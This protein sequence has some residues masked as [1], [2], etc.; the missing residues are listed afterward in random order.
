MQQKTKQMK[1][2][3]GMDLYSKGLTAAANIQQDSVKASTRKT[4]TA[5]V[6]ELADWLHSI[7]AAGKRTLQT[8]TPED[9]L[10]YFT[11]HWLPNHAGSATATGEFIAAPS[12]L[13]GIKSHLATEFETLG[14]LGPWD[15]HTKAGNPTHSK[16]I[17]DMLKGYGNQATQLGY[18]KKGA[19]PL[20]QAEMHL[21][22][23][24][25]EQQYHSTTDSAQLLLLTRD[26]LLFSMLWQT[27]FR[28]FNAGAVRL[29]NIVLPTGGSAL[30]FLVPATTLAAGAVLHV[31]PD[32]TKNKKGGHCPVTL[33]CD[34]LC[35]STWLERATHHYAVAG[36]PITNFLTRPLQ[37]GSKTLF[38]EKPMSSSNAWASLTKH[39][40]ALGIYT[41]QSVHSTRRGKMIHKQLNLHESHK[42]ISE[43]AMC[44]EQNAKYYTDIHRPTRLRM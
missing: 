27:C 43:A 5:A 11:Q 1:W 35:F 17:K 18:Q 31:L 26:A 8:V 40:K 29:D 3:F 36:Q 16:Q 41:G 24:S 6:R 10:V 22:L 44:N 25:M 2:F 33:T 15:A 9:M 39:L 14:R 32:N 12:S 23:S 28:G 13:S 38:A 19:V 20:S 37:P 30:P 7:Q 34:V 21:L 42:Q 4:R